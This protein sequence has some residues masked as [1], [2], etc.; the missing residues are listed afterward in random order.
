MQRQ[1]VV[2]ESRGLHLRL[3]LGRH[4]LHE[5]LSNQLRFR[6]HAFGHLCELR[7]Q[8]LRRELQLAGGRRDRISKPLL[9]VGLRFLRT[10]GL[11]DLGL[12][13]GVARGWRGCPG[14][15]EAPLFEHVLPQPPHV[16]EEIWPCRKRGTAVQLF[17]H[18]GDPRPRQPGRGRR[19]DR[20]GL[21]AG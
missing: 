18:A 5:Q 3:L 1:R 14:R 11:G 8:L 17:D 19:L 15:G 2:R 4:N 10:G 7:E 21:R 6:G 9:W 13:R 20:G 16:I 12:S